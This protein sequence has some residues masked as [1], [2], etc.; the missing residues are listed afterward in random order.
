MTTQIAI[1]PGDLAS[2]SPI[3]FGPDILSE[4]LHLTTR[5]RSQLAVPEK[6]LMF[7]VLADA[8]ETYQKHAFSKS[9]RQQVLFREAGEW[10]EK[11]ETG[12]LFS[13]RSICE[14]LGFDPAFL[15]LGLLRWPNNRKQNRSR[16]K[17]TQ[18]HSVRSQ[19]RKRLRSPASRVAR[20]SSGQ[21]LL[22]RC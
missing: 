22:I 5:R 1:T 12:Y 6:A 19:A 18:P 3:S 4:L 7:A 15:R 21:D 20:A 8:V 16:R 10:F 9:R 14:V 17:R 13:F 2:A 11:N